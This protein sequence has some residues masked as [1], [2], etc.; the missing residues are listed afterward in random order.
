MTELVGTDLDAAA[1]A[2]RAADGIVVA[3][4]VNPDGDALGSLLGLTLALDALGK[5]TYA[6]WGDPAIE[7]APSYRFLPGSDR[8][9]DPADVP[10]TDVFVALDCGAADRLGTLEPM[11]ARAPISVNIDHHPGNTNFATYNL[12][13]PGASSTAELVASLLVTLGVQVDPAIATCLYT[14]L[15]TDTGR[16]SY[17]STTPATLR[18][19]A[20]LV[21]AGADAPRIA[22]E[23]FESAP[24]GYLHLVG[25]VLDRAVLHAEERF[26]YSRI[27][28]RDLVESGVPMGETGEL[29][30]LV[31]ST[32]DADVAAL[33]KEQQDG[34]WRVS[35]RSRDREIG[36]I[37]RERGGGGH[38]L[39]A[40]YT[41]EDLEEG[42]NDL[43]RALRA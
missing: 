36:H 34:R 1:S 10:E 43:V 21:E 13:T 26:V 7:V 16:F 2:L 12:V 23:V 19:A 29:I 14:G 27:E 3:C 41:V 15:V 33:F 9:V 31:R 42:V 24:F 18:L 35:L 5:K 4:H 17:A 28:Q 40:G 25:R 37:A 38:D 22:T 20:D 30:D 6:S 8:I 32:R 11:A 39:A